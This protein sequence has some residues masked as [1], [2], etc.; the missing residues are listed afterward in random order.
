MSYV[1]ELSHIRK[2]GIPTPRR[3]GRPGKLETSASDVE[4]GT[5]NSQPFAGTWRRTFAQAKI[6]GMKNSSA[7]ARKPGRAAHNSDVSDHLRVSSYP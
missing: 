6:K 4:L 5:R 7:A 3:R 1:R 2:I